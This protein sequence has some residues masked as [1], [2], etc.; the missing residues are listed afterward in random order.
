MNRLEKIKFIRQSNFPE[1]AYAQLE[2]YSEPELDEI[3][4]KIT[5]DVHREEAEINKLNHFYIYLN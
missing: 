3:I 1:F 5:E 2:K 4:K